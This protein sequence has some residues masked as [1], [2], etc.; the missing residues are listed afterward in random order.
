M[1]TI[2]TAFLTLAMLF[3]V[4]T[5]HA[6]L[7][8]MDCMW[9]SYTQQFLKSY[10]WD[11]QNLWLYTFDGYCERFEV[12]RFDAD[13]GNDPGGADPAYSDF[14]AYGN[15]PGGYVGDDGSFSSESPGNPSGDEMG[16]ASDF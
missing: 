15:T 7:I 11:E 6:H 10:Y 13:A 8:L 9:N 5:A 4:N 16:D 14:E 3:L 2:R 1:L 12:M